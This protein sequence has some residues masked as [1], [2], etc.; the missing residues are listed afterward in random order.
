[1]S[2][3]PFETDAGAAAVDRVLAALAGDVRRRVLAYFEGRAENT[4]SLDDLVGHVAAV[5]DGADPPAPDRVRTR[6]HH[7]DLPKLQAVGL[8]DYDAAAG[9]VRYRGAPDAIEA[10][11]WSVLVGDAGTA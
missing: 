8:L 7:V 2:A 1:M 10:D 4:A 6:L 11:A 9:V 3:H 5:R